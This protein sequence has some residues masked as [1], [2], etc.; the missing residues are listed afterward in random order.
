MSNRRQPSAPPANQRKPEPPPAPPQ[1]RFEQ[2]DGF[3]ICRHGHRH[4]SI[5]AAA[6]CSNDN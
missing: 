3:V 1:K 5:V 6:A 4:G 2:V